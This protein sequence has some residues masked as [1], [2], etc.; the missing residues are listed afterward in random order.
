MHKLTKRQSN[1]IAGAGTVLNIAPKSNFGRL[2]QFDRTDVAA[3][4]GDW[5]KVGGDLRAAMTMTPRHKAQLDAA[6]D[7]AI[8]AIQREG[9]GEGK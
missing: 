7:T 9:E 5:E 4:R 8:A 2:R 1:L 6:I 3:L